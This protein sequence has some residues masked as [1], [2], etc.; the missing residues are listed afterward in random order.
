MVS[1]HHMQKSLLN[2][3]RTQLRLKSY[4]L[5]WQVV[6]GYRCHSI[7]RNEKAALL[8]WWDEKFV[9]NLHGACPGCRHV[10]AVR[11][12]TGHDKHQGLAK[13]WG[14]PDTS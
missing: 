10:I 5:S 9:G 12:Y 13:G 14:I 8:E 3:S 4:R 7:T 6:K 1:G 11:R 2:D